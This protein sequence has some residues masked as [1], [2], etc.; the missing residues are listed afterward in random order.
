MDERKKYLNEKSKEERYDTLKMKFKY[1]KG[2]TNSSSQTLHGK[3]K[4]LMISQHCKI[5]ASDG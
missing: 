2:L 5:K 4:S 1:Y 3:M